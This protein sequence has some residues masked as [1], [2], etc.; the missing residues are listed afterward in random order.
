[1]SRLEVMN[2]LTITDDNY[3]PWRWV[4]P[5]ALFRHVVEDIHVYKSISR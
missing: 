2:I 5:M 3:A 4:M 1:M